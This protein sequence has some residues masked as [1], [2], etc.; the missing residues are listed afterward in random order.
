MRLSTWPTPGR[1]TLE[2]EGADIMLVF[3]NAAL[4]AHS[5]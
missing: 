5:T 4:A 2:L 1:Q 3:Q